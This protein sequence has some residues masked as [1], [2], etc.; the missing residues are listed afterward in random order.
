MTKPYHFE[1]APENHPFLV[2]LNGFKILSGTHS[3]E[4]E[5]CLLECASEARGRKKTD[6]PSVAGLPDFRS[7]NDAYTDDESRTRDAAMVAVAC[8]TWP[9]VTREKR[10]VFSVKLAELVIRQILP[11]SLRSIGLN[12][13]A[14]RCEKEGTE[15]AARAAAYAADAADAADAAYAADAAANA[16]NAARA[17]DAANAAADRSLVLET[18]RDCVLEASKELA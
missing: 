18:F 14:E 9:D 6:D 8:W 11:I 16:A 10:Q 7:W 12:A 2:R 3:V 1:G 17:A 4:N 13:E 5:F 15:D